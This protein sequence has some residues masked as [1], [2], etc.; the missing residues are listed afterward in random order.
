MK[1][2]QIEIPN[3]SAALEKLSDSE[4]IKRAWENIK[5]NIKTSAKESLYEL[6]QHKQRFDEECLGFLDQRKRAKM[7]WIQDPSQSNVDNINRVR[8]G[9]SETFLASII[10]GNTIGKF[11]FPS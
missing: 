8:R 1:E 9:C 4:D 2:Y 11:F 7:R 5:K 6:K 3:K 10:D